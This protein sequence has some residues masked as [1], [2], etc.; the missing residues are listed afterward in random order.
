M[1]IIPINFNSLPEGL[2]GSRQIL[3]IKPT[4][5]KTI[6]VYPIH[7]SHK[8][9]GNYDAIRTLLD[10][11]AT[12]YIKGVWIFLPKDRENVLEASA[13]LNDELNVE[14]YVLE[15]GP[16]FGRDENNQPVQ[17]ILN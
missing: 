15:E 9:S 12:F 13:F 4:G 11:N 7:Q 17:E 1:K 16:Q 3:F 5:C 14:N 10:N 8:Q 6:R 2:S